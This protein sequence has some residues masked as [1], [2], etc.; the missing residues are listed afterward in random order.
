M[1]TRFF[2]ALLQV[3]MSTFTKKEEPQRPQKQDAKALIMFSAMK[4]P[5]PHKAVT[6]FAEQS[7]FTKPTDRPSEPKPVALIPLGD[8]GHALIRSFDDTPEAVREISSP[9]R[10]ALTVAHRQKHIRTRFG[11]PRKVGVQPY[12]FLKRSSKDTSV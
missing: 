11:H 5:V 4:K 12:I 8:S 7:F 10:T 1:K 6:P 9:R 3:N 2:V